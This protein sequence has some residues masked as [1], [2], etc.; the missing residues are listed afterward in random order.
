MNNYSKIRKS[1]KSIAGQTVAL[2]CY[3]AEVKSV[4][5]DT[6]TV[7]LADTTF[8]DVKLRAVEK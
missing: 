4:E 6:C 3:A 5:S 8:S 2:L 7:E 1:I